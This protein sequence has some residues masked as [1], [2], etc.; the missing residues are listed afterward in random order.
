[1]LGS[2]CVGRVATATRPFSTSSKATDSEGR[3]AAALV[4]LPDA[5]FAV[6]LSFGVLAGLLRPI[7][8]KFQVPFAA[9]NKLIWGDSIS[10]LRSLSSCEKTSARK[11]TPIRRAFAVRN[12]VALKFGSSATLRSLL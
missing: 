2:P 9:R 5:T 8:E 6:V 10:K 3:T 12:G 7:L 11:E 1:M 4:K